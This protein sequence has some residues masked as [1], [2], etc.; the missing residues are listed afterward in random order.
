MDNAKQDFGGN[1]GTQ[2]KYRDGKPKTPVLKIPMTD[3][4]PWRESKRH[5]ETENGERGDCD[6]AE[7]KDSEVEIGVSRTFLIV[8]T[9]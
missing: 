7:L 6:F 3:T 2:G 9:V 8:G 5:S 4:K 1:Q